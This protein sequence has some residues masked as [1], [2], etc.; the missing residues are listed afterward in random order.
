[1]KDDSGLLCDVYHCTQFGTEDCTILT[2][3][4]KSY[5]SK[6]LK[7]HENAAKYLSDFPS[8]SAESF[9]SGKSVTG[10]I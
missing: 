4:E 10:Y 9:D 2:I 5:F 6:W 3:M 7:A 8:E 1:M